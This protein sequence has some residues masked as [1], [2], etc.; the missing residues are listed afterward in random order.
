MAGLG[1]PDLYVV[2]RFLERLWRVRRPHGKTELQMAVRLNYSVYQ[3]YLDWMDEKGLVR[4]ETGAD[5]SAT[6]EATPKGLATYGTLVAWIRETVGE[7][8]L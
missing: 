1:R 6:V 4:L 7:D 8:H 2:A 5:G 3:R